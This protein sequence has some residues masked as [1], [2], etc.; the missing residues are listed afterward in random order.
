VVTTK[1]SGCPLPAALAICERARKKM[2]T[3]RC[4]YA[5]ET[6]RT[7]RRQKSIK[8]K[9]KKQN[10]YTQR[11]AERKHR[12]Q[13][14]KNLVI[15][16]DRMLM[17][18]FTDRRLPFSHTTHRHNIWRHAVLLKAPLVRAQ[19]TQA[20]LHLVRNA[21]AASGA[22]GL[23]H[24]GKVA[25]RCF[26]AAGVAVQRLGEEAGGRLVGGGLRAEGEKYG[27][28]NRARGK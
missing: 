28:R 25:G 21:H 18:T 7:K 5:K 14:F 9:I 12:D 8:F 16:K 26:D 23:I 11:N 15:K 2:D 22:H 10:E 17:T 1:P 27:Y 4:A 20:D 24:G 13:A 6:T 3:Q 19:S